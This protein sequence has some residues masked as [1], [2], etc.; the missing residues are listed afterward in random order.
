M[1]FMP[2]ARRVLQWPVQKE[3]RPRGGANPQSRP[4]LGSGAETRPREPG[5]LVIVDQHATVNVFPSLV[6]T[7]RQAT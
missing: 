2:G 7:A 3:A 6:H 4:Q 1:A 5:S